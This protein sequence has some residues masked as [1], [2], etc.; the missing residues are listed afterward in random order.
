MAAT[1]GLAGF[2]NLDRGDDRH[3]RSQAILLDLLEIV[4]D[5]LH[6]HALHDLHVVARGVLR[7]QEAEAGAAAALEAIDVGRKLDAG[8]RVDGHGHGLSGLHLGQLRLLE[9]GDHPNVRIDQGQQRL[10]DLH[11]RADLD[12]LAGDVPG[13]RGID[14]RVGEVQPGLPGLGFGAGHLGLGRAGLRSALRDLL[15][16]GFGAGA[17]GLGPSQGSLL[18]GNT[19]L[20][21]ANA[22]LRPPLPRLRPAGR[23]PLA[24]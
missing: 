1:V 21:L 18:S 4:E 5:D 13:N 17:L 16:G 8:V 20:G 6:G 9:V 7:R 12:A 24:P 3:P 23:P 11:V 22:A 14:F 19:R 2:I 15:G 10:T